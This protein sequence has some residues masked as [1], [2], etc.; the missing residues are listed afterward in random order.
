MPTEPTCGTCGRSEDFER[1]SKSELRP[2]GPGGEP[3]CYHCAFADEAAEERAKANFSVQFDA[4][5]AMSNMVV[6]GGGN[7][8]DPA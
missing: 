1:D 8:P 6:I 7:G 4:A 5:Q 3:I 2:Y